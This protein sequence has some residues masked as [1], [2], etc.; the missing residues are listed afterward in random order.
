MIQYITVPGT[1][2]CF[3]NLEKAPGAGKEPSLFFGYLF[4][5]RARAPG[6]TG[7]RVLDP[8]AIQLFFHRAH[9][10]LFFFHACRGRVA[11]VHVSGHPEGPARLAGAYRAGTRCVREGRRSTASDASSGR[12]RR[13]GY[14]RAR[15]RHTRCQQGDAKRKCNHAA[16]GALACPVGGD[17]C[18]PYAPHSWVILGGK[19]FPSIRILR[20]RVQARG[21]PRVPRMQRSSHE[22]WP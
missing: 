4:H 18:E 8:A 7:W 13:R 21:S 11:Q 3:L 12:Q 6:R 2:F 1:I 5:G 16:V 22:A 14:G 10:F 15:P 20:A 17:V 19:V 9:V